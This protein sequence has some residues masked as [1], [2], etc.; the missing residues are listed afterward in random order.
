M[1]SV[2][3]TMYNFECAKGS[4]KGQ[5]HEIFDFRFF[6]VSVSPKPLSIP[7]GP[8]LNFYFICGNIRSSRCT[9][10]V[11]GTGGKFINGIIDTWQIATVVIDTGGKFVTGVVDT[12]GKISHRCH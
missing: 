5:C 9:T 2:A 1:R 10:S 12:V 7:L 6:H 3:F 8:Y 11:A 4:L